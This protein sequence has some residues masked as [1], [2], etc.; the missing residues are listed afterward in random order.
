MIWGV[1]GRQTPSKGVGGK[2]RERRENDPRGISPIKK[3]KKIHP[4]MKYCRHAVFNSYFWSL[5]CHYGS[6]SFTAI[7]LFFIKKK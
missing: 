4:I 3:R 1:G 7:S 2:M 5:K 6:L